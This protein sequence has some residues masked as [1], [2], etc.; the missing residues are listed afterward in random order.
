MS[1]PT[2]SPKKQKVTTNVENIEKQLQLSRR[3]R[4]RPSLS[5]TE[6]LDILFVNFT[7]NRY[8]LLSTTNSETIN[9]VARTA[10]LLGRGKGT[11]STVVKNCTG[12]YDE[13]KTDT[14]KL[15]ATVHSTTRNGNK[16]SHATKILS[17]NILYISVRDFVREKRSKY[18]RVTS[19]N[20]LSFLKN[21]QFIQSND[22]N[23]EIQSNESNKSDL[24]TI[25]RWV[26]KNG[27]KRGS[28]SKSIGLKPYFIA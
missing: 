13:Y 2:P 10:E 1:N 26:V 24:R 3:S 15:K 19:N 5:K 20:V 22:R 21:C 17:A 12:M 14:D 25:Q 23:Y 7:I 6:K 8:H 18:E 16:E 28:K 4:G 9:A 27:F 11:V